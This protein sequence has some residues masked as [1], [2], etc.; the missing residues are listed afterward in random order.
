MNMKISGLT[1]Q[2]AELCEILWQLDG[3]MMMML[4]AKYIDSLDLGD[5]VQAREVCERIR[6]L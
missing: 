5:C 4:L 3:A 1:P 6:Q 2:R